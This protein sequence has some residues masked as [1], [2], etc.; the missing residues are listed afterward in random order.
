MDEY[1]QVIIRNK[2]H[3][4]LYDR[5]EPDQSTDTPLRK[6]LFAMPGL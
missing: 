3:V 2:E 4:N 1:Y 5:Y 6:T